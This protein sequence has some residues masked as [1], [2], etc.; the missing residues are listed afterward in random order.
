[1]NFKTQLNVL[2]NFLEELEIQ[3]IREKP[4][5]LETLERDTLFSRDEIKTVYRKFKEV[6]C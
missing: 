4:Q 2:D 6:S 1:M 5:N 3:G